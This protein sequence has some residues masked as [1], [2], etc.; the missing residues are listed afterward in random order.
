MSIKTVPDIP[1]IIAHCTTTLFNSECE[2]LKHGCTGCLNVP[3]FLKGL[4]IKFGGTPEFC[5][6]YTKGVIRRV[7]LRRRI[8]KSLEK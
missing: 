4:Y 3:Q 2:Y 1:G 6:L 5:S 8:I 7:N